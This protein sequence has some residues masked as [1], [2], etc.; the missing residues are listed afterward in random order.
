MLDAVRTGNPGGDPTPKDVERF[1]ASYE[2][3]GG[4]DFGIDGVIRN[5]LRE[6]LGSLTVTVTQDGA[7]RRSGPVWEP[8]NPVRRPHT[9]RLW[10]SGVLHIKMWHL[11]DIGEEHVYACCSRCLLDR[12]DSQAPL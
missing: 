7:A 9:P 1:G 3:T 11:P 12:G 6:Y 2:M 5:G 4:A 10:N 8:R